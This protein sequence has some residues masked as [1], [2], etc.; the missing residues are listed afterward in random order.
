MLLVW[1]SNSNLSE[2]TNI[3]T[4]YFKNMKSKKNSFYISEPENKEL[5][6]KYNLKSL[7][8]YTSSDDE[9]AGLWKDSARPFGEQIEAINNLI[10]YFNKR[11]T[12]NLI[13]RLHP[14]LNNKSKKEQKRWVNLPSSDYVKIILPG[15]KIDSYE[16]MSESIGVISYG[17]TIGLEAAYYGK[18]SAVLAQ[19]YYDLLGCVTQ[20][21]NFLELSKWVDRI[22]HI[23]QIELDDRRSAALIRGYYMSRAGIHFS[24]ANLLQIGEGSWQCISFLGY[25][26]E[27]N[28][29]Q[30]RYYRLMHKIQLRKRRIA[31]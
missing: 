20:I 24:N 25:R 6:F 21:S 7:V 26:I 3:G 14:N 4:E 9:V 30:N 1:N 10:E 11:K 29:F 19:C 2:K 8:F 17:S 22:N 13:I 31:F 15:A 16:L 5:S 18:P 23:N 28:K 12:H 27:P